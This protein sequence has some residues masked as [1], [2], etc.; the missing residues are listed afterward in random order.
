[1]LIIDNLRSSE[2]V[3]LAPKRNAGLFGRVAC[4]YAGVQN[5]RTYIETRSMDALKEKN[6]KSLAKPQSLYSSRILWASRIIIHILV[7]RPC[8][9]PLHARKTVNCL[10]RFRS[11]TEERQ[12]RGPRVQGRLEPPAGSVAGECFFVFERQGQVQRLVDVPV[13]VFGFPFA[14]FVAHVCLRRHHPDAQEIQLLFRM[15]GELSV[16]PLKRDCAIRKRAPRL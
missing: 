14:V 3:E 16:A 10:C 4:Q 9:P 8:R 2:N 7:M 15:A 12:D 1:M 5:V 6:D 11:K 13:V